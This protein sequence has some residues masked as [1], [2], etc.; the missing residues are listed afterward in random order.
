VFLEREEGVEKMNSRKQRPKTLGKSDETIVPKKPANKAEGSVAELVEERGST[1][2]NSHATT[3]GWVQNQRTITSGLMRVREA[4]KRNKKEVFSSLLHHITIPVLVQSFYRIKRD[5]KTGADG[6]SWKDYERD[7]SKNLEEL[8]NELQKGSYRPI[9]AKRI[10]ILKADG[11]KRPIS[12]QSMR[13]KVAQ[14]AVASVLEQIYEEDFLGFSYGFRPGRGQHD[15]LDAVHVGLMGKKINWVLDMDIRKFF[16]TIEHEWLLKFIGH[17]VSDKRIHRLITK[18][19]KVGYYDEKGRRVHADVGVAQG[20]VISPLLG[21][22]VLHYVFDLWIQ[23]RRKREGKGDSIII[24]YA[25]D[26]VMGFQSEWEARKAYEAIIQRF[27][28]FGLAINEEKTKIIEFGRY[29]ETSRRRKG[30]GKPETFDFLGFTHYCGKTRKTKSYMVWRKTI[31]KRLNG[32]LTKVRAELRKRMH[33]AIRDQAV[34][35]ASILNGHMNY[36]SVPGNGK[37][38][39]LFLHEVQNAWYKTLCRRSQKKRLNWKKFSVYL[40]T[41]LP[42]FRVTHPY[43]DQRFYAKYSR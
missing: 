35:L 26:T 30:K 27:K 32:T 14:Q 41:K 37:A 38:V 8:H 2:R 1:E 9:P 34:W 39:N 17:R 21:N 15:A 10:Y 24:R 16:D 25:D 33:W 36:Y 19:I 42:T 13:D 7:L 3:D 29:A 20:D 23:A 28:K 22:I 6:V 12:M 18:W 31:R 40:C 5:A 43:P 11:S 4:A